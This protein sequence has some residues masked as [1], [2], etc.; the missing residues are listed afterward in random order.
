MH[1]ELLKVDEDPAVIDRSPHVPPMLGTSQIAF[2]AMSKRKRHSFA[3]HL[4]L[5]PGRALSD[6]MDRVTSAICDPPLESLYVAVNVCAEPLPD[7]GVTE[8][9][10]AVASATVLVFE[11]PSRNREQQRMTATRTFELLSRSE[12]K[13]CAFRYTESSKDSFM[14]VLHPV[15]QSPETCWQTGIEDPAEFSTVQLAADIKEPR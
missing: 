7:D 15:G 3:D 6:M 1:C 10:D 4:D 14:G 11:Q 2:V 9:G 5:P 8:T 12:I 13:A